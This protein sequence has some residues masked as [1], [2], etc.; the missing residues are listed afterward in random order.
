MKEEVKCC[1]PGVTAAMVSRHSGTPRLALRLQGATGG[2]PS[3]PL[4]RACQQALPTLRSHPSVQPT[5][6]H[7]L[8][9]LRPS[10][11]ASW[12]AWALGYRHSSITAEGAGNR[13]YHEMRES[14]ASASPPPTL[15]KEA[16]P[17]TALFLDAPLFS[18]PAGRGRRA[19]FFSS[20]DDPVQHTRLSRLVVPAA[21]CPPPA[22][23]QPLAALTA[24]T[25]RLR[26]CQRR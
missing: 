24:L 5:T 12:H 2:A 15:R 10:T 9:L 7:R 8:A 23:L 6:P 25:H 11:H 19:E 4:R 21:G 1:T 13:A 16:L 14:C 22:A 20:G 17:P 26:C 18:M 3:H